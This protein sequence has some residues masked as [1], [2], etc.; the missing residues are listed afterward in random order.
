MNN[1]ILRYTYYPCVTKSLTVSYQKSK[2]K[3]FY[4]R[5]DLKPSCNR[6]RWRKNI[7]S[8]LNSKR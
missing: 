8:H 5:H 3:E 7:K 4:C 1:L 6:L 2:N